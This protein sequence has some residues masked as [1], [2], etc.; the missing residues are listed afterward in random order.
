MAKTPSQIKKELGL[1]KGLREKD[2]RWKT[3]EEIKET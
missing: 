2:K 1:T 3:P